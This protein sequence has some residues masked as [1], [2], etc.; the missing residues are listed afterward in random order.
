MSTPYDKRSRRPNITRYEIEDHSI[1]VKVG[2]GPGA[3]F[4]LPLPDEV[5]RPQP[6]AKKPLLIQHSVPQVVAT[7]GVKWPG[8]LLWAWAFLMTGVTAI[9]KSLN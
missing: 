7:T 8:W 3:S 1:R 6:K 9:L 5:P 4:K 2:D